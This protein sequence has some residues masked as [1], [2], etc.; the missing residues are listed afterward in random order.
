MPLNFDNLQP[1]YLFPN[2]HGRKNGKERTGELGKQSN[3]I[4]K[5]NGINFSPATGQK[6][7]RANGVYPADKLNF[8]N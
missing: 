8:G 6:E 2:F 5:M 1:V 3:Q 7:S 4:R